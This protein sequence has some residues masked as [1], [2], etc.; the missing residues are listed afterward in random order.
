M[1]DSSPDFVAVLQFCEYYDAPDGKAQAPPDLASRLVGTLWDSSKMWVCSVDQPARAPELDHKF[2]GYSVYSF[3]FRTPIF[4]SERTVPSR[5]AVL[6]QL[7][8]GSGFAY[9]VF[10]M[11]YQTVK[12]AEPMILPD[13]RA[14][15][16]M[17]L[18]K[19]RAPPS[20]KGLANVLWRQLGADGDPR[21]YLC[22]LEKNPAC[23]PD[24]CLG[25]ASGDLYPYR[26]ALVYALVKMS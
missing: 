20:T 1:Q 2:P 24:I 5:S 15:H 12:A 6:V 3:Q 21:I 18:G 22:K 13:G 14:A 4:P 23:D 25:Y 10:T 11:T 19:T 9:D 7:P 8:A 17:Q 26:V 16:V